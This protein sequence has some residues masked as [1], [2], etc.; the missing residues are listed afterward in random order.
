M[1]PAPLPPN[2]WHNG[3]CDVFLDAAAIGL[4]IKI[5]FGES[6]AC[7]HDAE[8]CLWDLAYITNAVDGLLGRRDPTRWDPYGAFGADPIRIYATGP[9]ISSC[10]AA[11]HGSGRL[12]AYYY[13]CVSTPIAS[14]SYRTPCALTIVAGRGGR[15]APRG[16]V[17]AAEGEDGEE[18][19]DLSHAGC[20]MR[21]GSHIQ[22]EGLA[23]DG[24]LASLLSGEWLVGD[25]REA[26]EPFNTFWVYRQDGDYHGLAVNHSVQVDAAAIAAGAT[27]YARCVLQPVPS[28]YEPCC[29]DTYVYPACPASGEGGGQGATV[30][31]WVVS[32]LVAVSALAGVL[33]LIAVRRWRKLATARRRAGLEPADAVAASGAA[34]R[35]SLLASSFL[36]SEISTTPGRENEPPATEDAAVDPSL[37]FDWA[38]SEDE[39][40]RSVALQEL[41]AWDVM[42]VDVVLDYE[43]ESWLSSG[44]VVVVTANALGNVGNAGEE[45]DAE[46]MN[47]RL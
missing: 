1:P 40:A 39:A 47:G 24:P 18:D 20:E 16:D 45:C 27:P 7:D 41:P 46:S 37:V 30:G 6:V 36:S 31:W 11:I 2:I 33:I 12:E 43:N 19:K 29:N 9:I 17:A 4:S 3:T 21:P 10:P 22:F 25:T 42:N 15:C 23:P 8:D 5:R 38:M 32:A 34:A 35:S 44:N 28:L 26:D 13:P 14:V